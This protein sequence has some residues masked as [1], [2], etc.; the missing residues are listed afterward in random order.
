M[1][2]VLSARTKN[3]LLQVAQTRAKYN[4]SDNNMR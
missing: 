4:V 2:I 3:I 1:Y